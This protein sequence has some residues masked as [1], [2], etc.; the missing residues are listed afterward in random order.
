MSP[1]SSP[2][3]PFAAYRRYRRLVRLGQVLFGVG[4][5]IAAVHLVMHLT[6]SPSGLTD[7]AAGYPMAGLI[8]I[9]GAVLAGQTEPKR[10]K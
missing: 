9:V 3:D 4:G 5:I 6:G 1:N 7:L 8:F 10:K 2:V